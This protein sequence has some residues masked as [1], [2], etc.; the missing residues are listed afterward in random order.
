LIDEVGFNL[1]STIIV[2]REFLPLI[3][4]SEGKKIGIISSVLGSIEYA[5]NMIGLANGYSIAKAALNM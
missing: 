2:V 3:R 1:K 4:K 5:G